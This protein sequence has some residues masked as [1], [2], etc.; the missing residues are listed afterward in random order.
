MIKLLAFFVTLTGLF[1]TGAALWSNQ[2]PYQVT[3]YVLTAD[4]VVPGN[5]VVLNGV[6][7]GKVDRVAVAPEDSQA[8]ALIT[9]EVDRRYSPLRQGT[10]LTVRPKGVLGTMFLDLQQGGGAP[11]A[12]GG[13]IP[14]QDTAVPVT[15]DEVNDI[16]DPQTRAWVHTLTVQG[17]ATFNGRGQDLN[18]VIALLPQLSQDA[19]QISGSL[20][21][22]DQQLDQLA[23]EFDRVATMMAS[24]AEAFKRD[25]RN[26]ASLLTV[27]AQHEQKIQDELVYAEA[28]LSK[29]NA[30]LSGHEGDLNSILKQMPGLLDQLKAF[31][32]RSTTALSIIYPC[33]GDI[34]ATLA[35][36]QSATGYATP[37]GATDNK[38]FELRTDSQI[39][40]TGDSN[41]S[42]GPLVQCSGA[43]A[44]V[45]GSAP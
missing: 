34:L 22:R 32:D 39:V 41:G 27:L 15:L 42:F 45:T 19:K 4:Q 43:K 33:T 1:G 25:I 40:R 28:A 29:L 5:D 13:R 11:I 2:Q 37:Q 24:E 38:G 18:K 31:Q 7:A 23:Q 3:A 16:F 26:G 20:A 36:M 44:P 17:G 8:G 12:G 21:S 30:A 6:P 9:F 35:E 10:K 14:L